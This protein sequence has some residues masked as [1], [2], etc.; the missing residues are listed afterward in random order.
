[1]ARNKKGQ[2]TS[3]HIISVKLLKSLQE[4]ADDVAIRVKPIVRDK[5]ESELRYQLY[6]SYTP[7]TQK[8]KEIR[9]Y[10]ESN[11]HQKK[12]LYHHTGLLASSVYGTIDGD[13]VK[14]NIKDQKYDNGASTT[15]VY[16]YLKFGTTDKPKNYIYDYA[17]NSK[18]AMYVSQEP[19]NFEA[20]TREEMKRFLDELAGDLHNDPGKYSD[21]YTNKVK[22]R[23]LFDK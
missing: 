19:H 15:E 3:E 16:D 7:A 14:A 18:Y 8:G 5:L 13:I 4:I 10:N 1:M 6:Q 2:I 17:N 12:N 9:E 11:T 20:R 23:H 22:A 21:K